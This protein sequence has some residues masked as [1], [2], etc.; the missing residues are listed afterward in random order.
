MKSFVLNERYTLLFS[1]TTRYILDHKTNHF[2]QVNLDLVYYRAVGC[3]YFRQSDC[4]YLLIL[5]QNK[6]VQLVRFRLL[7]AL[8]GDLKTVDL[9]VCSEDLG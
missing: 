6:M 9:K 8:A 3:H 4:V 1:M 5:S 2:K 7:D